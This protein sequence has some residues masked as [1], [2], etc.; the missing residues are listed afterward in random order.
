[1]KPAWLDATEY[2]FVHHYFHIGDHKLHYIDEGSG[3]TLL[4]VHGTPSWSFDFRNVIR[5]L[6]DQY[7]CVAFDHMGFGMSDKPGQYDYSTINHIRTLQLFI[8]QLELRNIT[9]V[10]HDFGGPIGFG[11]ALR[12]PDNIKRIVILNSWLWNCSDDPDY[13]KARKLLRSPLVPFLYRYLNFSPRFVLPQAIVYTKLSKRIRRHYTRPFAKP[14][15]RNGP[16]AFVNSLLNDQE[17]FE[18]LWTKRNLLFRKPTLIIWGMRDPIV[19]T[20]YL[21]KFISGFPNSIVKKLDFSGHFPQEEQPRL[22][23]SFLQSFLSKR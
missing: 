19:S 23:S 10:V 14:S 9:L 18:E 2:P 6:R 12:D 7:R 1:M 5:E 21:M 17:C 16:L 15:Q 13:I 11:A 22:V 4:F 20:R 8:Q 3:E